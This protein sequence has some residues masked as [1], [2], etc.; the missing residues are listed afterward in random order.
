MNES[1]LRSP[2]HSSARTLLQVGGPAI[3]A[4]GALFTA[5]GIGSF[6]MA[7]GSGGPPRFFWCGF[8]GMPMMFV[9]MV[10]CMF[11]YI[12]VIH[13]Y[14]AGE[15]APVAKD[16]VNYLGENTQ[17]GVKAMSKA[18]AEGVIEAQSEQRRR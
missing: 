5:V 15:S 11:G 13:R 6:F 9:G 3:L 2:G 17:P 10:M 12:G 4:S 7:I 8:L 1:Q 18:I 14:L 16:V